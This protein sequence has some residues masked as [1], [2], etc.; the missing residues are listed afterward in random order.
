M[1]QNYLTHLLVKP[2]LLTR[3]ISLRLLYR[4]YV[5]YDLY[6]IQWDFEQREVKVMLH[7][8]LEL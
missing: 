7:Q 4:L 2:K 3:M 1:L 6:I 8:S 5:T